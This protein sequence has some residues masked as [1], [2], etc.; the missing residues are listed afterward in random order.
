VT[1]NTIITGFG[2]KTL[3]GNTL[4]T[5]TGSKAVTGNPVN[6]DN[7]NGSTNITS[8]GDTIVTDN[9]NGSTNITGFG[10]GSAIDNIFDLDSL[11]FNSIRFVKN[12]THGQIYLRKEESYRD[13]NGKPRHKNCQNI[14]KVESQTG[15]YIFYPEFIEDFLPNNNECYDIFSKKGIHQLTLKI[16]T[17]NSSALVISLIILLS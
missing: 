15:Q 10:N 5:C 11:V 6:A 7:V 16:L 8:F 2:S 4:F 3:T 9:G 17:Q 1:G 12:K 14:G 13:E